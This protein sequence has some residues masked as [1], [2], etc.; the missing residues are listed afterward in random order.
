MV[1]AT[2]YIILVDT[3]EQKNDHILNYF[4]QNSIPYRLQKLDYGDYSI[5]DDSNMVMPI[6]IE[7]K[8]SID[9][10]I[11]NFTNGRERFVEE[12]RRAIIKQCT[13]IL[14][15]E[16]LYGYKKIVHGVY[17]SKMNQ[18]ALLGSLK[19]FES[20]YFFQTSFIQKELA[21]HFIYNTLLYNA[22]EYKK[23]IEFDNKIFSSKAN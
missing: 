17:R 12:F 5:I 20:R 3:R 21:G 8:A 23:L 11:N 19:T 13:L 7:R 10:L 1:T 2:N 22:R 6:S 14:M 4:K 18:N 15:V 9:E 16:D